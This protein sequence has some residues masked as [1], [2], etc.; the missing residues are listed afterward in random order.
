MLGRQEIRAKYDAWLL[1]VKAAISKPANFTKNIVTQVQQA[2]IKPIAIENQVQQVEKQI[3]PSRGR[4][5]KT[6]V[7]PQAAILPSRNRAAKT[8]AISAIKKSFDVI[9]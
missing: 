8:K 4:A 5:A 7:V 2:A 1:G 9:E 3:L 6:C